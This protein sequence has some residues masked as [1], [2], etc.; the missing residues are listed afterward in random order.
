MLLIGALNVNAPELSGVAPFLI[1]LRTPSIA[2]L[3]RIIYYTSLSCEV[4]PL[5]IH[6][7]IRVESSWVRNTIGESGEVGLMQVLPATASKFYPLDPHDS[8]H[9]II[10]G[11]MHFKTCLTQ[12]SGNVRHAVAAYNCGISRAKQYVRGKRALPWK[13]VR[14]LRK[15][16]FK[17]L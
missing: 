14:H 4:N 7:I 11:I 16:N 13:T 12:L 15:F 8:I 1:P 5:I 2:D 9:N 6:E 17:N 3:R 10:I